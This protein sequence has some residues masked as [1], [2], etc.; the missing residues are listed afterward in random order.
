MAKILKNTTGSTID[1][2]KLGLSIPASNQITIETTDYALLASDDSVVELTT[3]INNE[4]IVVNNGTSDLSASQGLDYI[5]YPDNSNSI[6][7]DNTGIDISS[8]D[9]TGALSDLAN[10]HFGK[11]YCYNALNSFSTTSTTAQIVLTCSKDVPSGMYRIHWSF[12]ITNSKENTNGRVNV[13]Y[14]SLTS[15]IAFT[16]DQ[17][18][19]NSNSINGFISEVSHSGGTLTAT[20]TLRRIAGNGQARLS[21]VKVEIWRVS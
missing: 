17:Q 13:G 19:L 11:E 20:V 15:T 21:D 12:S 18:G 2:K 14:T 5:K 9:L 8:T 4:D 16:R 6:I 10:R 7:I 1:L 3:L